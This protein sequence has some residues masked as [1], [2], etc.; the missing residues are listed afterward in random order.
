MNTFKDYLKE[1]SNVYQIKNKMTVLEHGKDVFKKYKDI[2]NSNIFPEF[3]KYL[4][5][6]S[7]MKRYLTYHDIGKVSCFQ[8]DSY[9]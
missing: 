7:T 3:R 5:P 2:I 6:I 8:E 9:G 4:Y 1:M